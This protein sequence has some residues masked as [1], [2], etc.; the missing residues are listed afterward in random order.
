METTEY[1]AL[2]SSA[3]PLPWHTVFQAIALALGAALSVM[4]VLSRHSSFQME[5]DTRTTASCLFV[6]GAG[7]SAASDPFIGTVTESDTYY[8]GRLHELLRPQYCATTRFMHEDTINASWE[9]A[10]LQER[11]CAV[12]IATQ[13]SVRLLLFSHSMGNLVVAGALDA[14]RCAL[15]PT[16]LWF[17]VAAPWAG[18]RAADKLPEVCSGSQQVVGSL[19]KTLASREHFCEGPGGSPSAGLAGLRTDNVGLREIARRWQWRVNGSLC[20]SSA[21]GL[22][23]TEG[24]GADSYELQAL[25]ELVDFREP[26]DGAVPTASCHPAGVGAPVRSWSS[27]AHLTAAV[28]HFDLTCRHGDGWL[29]WLATEERR[30]CAWYAAMAD[31]A[32]S[33]NNLT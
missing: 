22:W 7:N 10:E 5:Y 6:H 28:N 14:G 32:T 17:A 27:S 16:A 29:P 21:F 4:A 30:P 11:F 13:P 33:N 20:G 12:L 3:M 9:D 1:V 18:S 15:P 25:A 24:A 23:L 8:W 31:A 19:V 2:P 26:N